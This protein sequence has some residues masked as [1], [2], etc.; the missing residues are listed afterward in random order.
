MAIGM[1]R[2][3]VRPFSRGLQRKRVNT[4]FPIAYKRS[5]HE[6]L[7]IE[8]FEKLGSQP[9]PNPDSQPI[10]SVFIC[11]TNRCGSNH[12]AEQLALAISAPAA[13]QPAS[14]CG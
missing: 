2:K 6:R 3:S 1:A 4:D 7:I 14:T 12:L 8:Y 9:E 5:N 10:P 11:F 13:R